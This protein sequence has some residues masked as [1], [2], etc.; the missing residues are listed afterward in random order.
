MPSPGE[1]HEQ[2]LDAVT[3]RDFD[4]LRALYHE[5]YTYTASDGEERAGAD[6]GVAVAQM[7]TRAFP[8]LTL[9]VR[10]RYATA[11]ASVIEFT[12]RGTHEDDLDGIPATGKRVEVSVCNV[13]EARDG[14]ILKE[15]EYFDSQAMMR[16]LGVVE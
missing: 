7:Y 2:M 8:D 4:A 6:A 3:R 15:R 12:A 16:Q 9:D 1:L 10:H 11:D 14:T 13:I 5:D